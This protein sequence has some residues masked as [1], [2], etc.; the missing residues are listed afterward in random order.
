MKTL[1]WLKIADREACPDVCQC[2]V[3]PRR[4][5]H[6]KGR[7]NLQINGYCFHFCGPEGY[8]QA[9]KKGGKE[10]RGCR[11]EFLGY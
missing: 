3:A 9:S 4:G 10:C 2:K 1:F 8:C 7:R 5:E 11:M 6:S